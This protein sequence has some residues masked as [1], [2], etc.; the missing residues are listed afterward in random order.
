MRADA[1]G[2]ERGK[3]REKE[4]VCVWYTPPTKPQPTTTTQTNN[5]T[6]TTKKQAALLAAQQWLGAATP[7]LLERMALYLDHNSATRA[8]LFKPVRLRVRAVSCVVVEAFV[9]LHIYICMY[10]GIYIYTEHPPNKKERA[11]AS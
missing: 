6:I 1:G 8:I 5:K 4:K 10:V 11:F 9:P 7:A 2:A 3:E